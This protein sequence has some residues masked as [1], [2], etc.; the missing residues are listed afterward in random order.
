MEHADEVVFVPV[1]AT[2]SGTSCVPLKM[3]LVN[4]DLTQGGD[5]GLTL[6]KGQCVTLT[7]SGKI[8][9]GEAKFVLIPST[10]S[11]QVYGVHVVASEGANL[12]LSCALPLT[13]S[14]CSVAH[15]EE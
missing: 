11:G 4:G 14:S 6:A 8:S 12:E 10:T 15:Q 1:N 13:S 5:H 9:F 7:F 3:E 2:V